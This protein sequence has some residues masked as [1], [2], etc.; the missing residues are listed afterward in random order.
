MPAG[1]AST[2]PDEFSV[3]QTPD[4][5][6]KPVT[7]V[8]DVAP[9]DSNSLDAASVSV[10]APAGFTFDLSGHPAAVVGQVVALSG[11]TDADRTDADPAAHT[12]DACAPGLHA[13][14]WTATVTIGGT[15]TP[16]TL[17]SIR[18]QAPR[19]PWALTASRTARPSCC[20]SASR[21]S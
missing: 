1:S 13:A 17:T 4:L 6:G 8:F 18:R 7:I 20:C 15:A 12:N 2:S 19:P 10:Y 21:A 5:V 3:E 11:F 9:F 16:I 14:V